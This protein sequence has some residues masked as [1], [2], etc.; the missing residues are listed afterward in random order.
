MAVHTASLDGIDAGSQ[1]RVHPGPGFAPIL[2]ANREGTCG[3]IEPGGL[4][5][6][7]RFYT[8]DERCQAFK[9]HLKVSIVPREGPSYILCQDDVFSQ[10]V[11]P[12]K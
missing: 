11:L 4:R 3:L 10:R 6:S 2:S 12:P 9:P 7:F 1:V 8:L 5:A